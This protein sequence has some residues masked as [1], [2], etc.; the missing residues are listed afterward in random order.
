MH[1][2]HNRILPEVERGAIS[3]QTARPDPHLSPFGQLSCHL[4]SSLRSVYV[5][6]NMR[7]LVKERRLEDETVGMGETVGEG[8]GWNG[9]R[10]EWETV[11]I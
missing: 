8:Y 10:L 4:P 3:R 7:R 11:G 5:L 2:S 6:G 9:R 1:L